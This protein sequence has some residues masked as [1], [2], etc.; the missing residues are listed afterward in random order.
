MSQ[1]NLGI[2]RPLSLGF[3]RRATRSFVQGGALIAVACAA[4]SVEAQSI[5]SYVTYDS[6][7]DE[8]PAAFATIEF[9]TCSTAYAGMD[10]RVYLEINGNADEPIDLDNPGD[11]REA[12]AIDEYAFPFP[13]GRIG[14]L[15]SFTIVNPTMD[16]WCIEDI[17]ISVRGEVIW[18]YDSHKPLQGDSL[19]AGPGGL[20]YDGSGPIVLDE[21]AVTFTDEKKSQYF[22]AVPAGQ[23]C[24]PGMPCVTLAQPLPAHTVTGYAGLPLRRSERWKYVES[25]YVDGHRTFAPCTLPTLV[26]RED[27]NTQ[28]KSATGS[29]ISQDSKLYWGSGKSTVTLTTPGSDPVYKARAT[30]SYDAPLD[31][32]GVS[33]TTYIHPRCGLVDGALSLSFEMS[34]VEIGTTDVNFLNLLV[35]AFGEAINKGV[36]FPTIAP[37]T[38]APSVVPGCAKFSTNATTGDLQMAWPK[39]Y[40]LSSFK[41]TAQQIKDITTEYTGVTGDTLVS[42]PT[43]PLCIRPSTIAV[44]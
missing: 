12:G 23:Y 24:A 13:G 37:P 32:V 1:R 31:D 29:H 34:D 7:L 26:T 33:A 42:L 30:L 15:K 4:G 9:K 18:E 38:S 22:P 43:N 5:A 28:F 17:K 19:F 14:S 41:L 39:T 27:F 35:G 40:K 16:G 3:V 44:P 10:G 36:S 11:D 2:G 20:A 6:R 25:Y 21:T 8:A